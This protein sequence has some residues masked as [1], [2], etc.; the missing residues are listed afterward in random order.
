MFIDVSRTL[1]SFKG[2]D[3]HMQNVMSGVGLFFGVFLG[4]LSI[5]VLFGLVTALML[6]HSH[7]RRFPSIETCLVSLIA[8]SSYLFATAIEMSG[9]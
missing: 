1:Q 9:M 6:K 5:G 3:L 7:V 2:K 8:Y 4:S